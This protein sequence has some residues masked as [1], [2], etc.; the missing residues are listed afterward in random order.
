MGVDGRLHG[1]HGLAEALAQIEGGMRVVAL[2]HDD[3]R[4]VGGDARPVASAQ[5]G[6][7]DRGARHGG[8]TG[9]FPFG[10][11]GVGGEVRARLG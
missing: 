5:R 6:A 8:S 4:L 9:V 7:V 11:G 3:R 10:L 1:D 2:E